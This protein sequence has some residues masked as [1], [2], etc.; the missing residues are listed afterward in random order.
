[1]SRLGVAIDEGTTVAILGLAYKPLSH[2]L[3]ESQAV[4]LAGDLLRRGARVVAHDP[5]AARF[6]R[7]EL[8]DLGF[9]LMSVQ[10]CL[11]IASVVVIASPEPIYAQLDADDFVRPGRSTTVIV[12]CWRLLSGKFSNRTDIRYVALGRSLDDAGND[13]RLDSL[14]FDTLER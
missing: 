7:D 1:M 13:A 8:A 2:A 10:E 11:D 12:D 14:F 6:S 4:L 9:T 3:D 5:L